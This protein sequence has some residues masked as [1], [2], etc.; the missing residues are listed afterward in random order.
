[1][2]YI[3]EHYGTGILSGTAAFLLLSL[4]FRMLECGG[5]LHTLVTLYTSGIAG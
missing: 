3:L 2:K 5:A 1:M 4:F